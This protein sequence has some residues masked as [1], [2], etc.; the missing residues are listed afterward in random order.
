MRTSTAVRCPSCDASWHADDA[1][2]CGV[3][4]EHLQPLA[5]P[6]PA[7]ARPWLRI[8][9]G[10][11]VVAAVGCGLFAVGGISSL[12]LP[13]RAANP[14]VELGQEQL[15]LEGEPLSEAERAAALAPFDEDRLRCEPEG[16]ERWRVDVEGRPRGRVH[17]TVVDDLVVAAF[18]GEV[19][20]YD[21]DS[22]EER[23]RTAWPD[24][25]DAP[26][27]SSDYV[28]IGHAGSDVLVV[29]WLPTGHVLALDRRGRVLWHAREGVR[30]YIEPVGEVVVAA[31]PS[32]V[33]VALDGGGD[34]GLVFLKLDDL[35]MLD[36]RTG[37]LLW[38]AEAVAVQARLGHA[39]VLHDGTTARL[40]DART[41]EEL[42]RR[43]MAQVPWLQ[44]A[45]EVLVY[46]GSD[47]EDRLWRLLSAG[48]LGDVAEIGPVELLQPSED[49]SV[50]VGQVRGDTTTG[51]RVLLFEPD[52]TLRWEHEL[53]PPAGS[54]A[55][56]CSRP[57]VEGDDLVLPPP[58]GATAPL[59]FE[60]S[61]G[62]PRP[63]PPAVPGSSP[64]PDDGAGTWWAS[65]HTAL[66]RGV[67]A[68][69]T[70]L[71]WHDGYRMSLRGSFSGPLT[72]EPPLVFTGWGSIIA[73]QPV[74][75]D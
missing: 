36:P 25:A 55:T 20:G 69:D 19:F 38:E 60:L 33:E 42:A 1:R 21:L 64:A 73:V 45:G 3:C 2:F 24:A 47:S 22:G 65:P 18:R 56:C 16:C 51:D 6:E 30:G 54:V 39:L 43:T 50:L 35:R 29:G 15:A 8:A 66:I 63:A 37:G 27:T 14:A 46:A 48:D 59:R 58:A 12:R 74:P 32:L 41:G 31:R 10:L 72:T 53:P 13:Q 9:V 75:R 71:V 44:P 40:H 26:P 61:D 34:V 62:T 11:V 4:G 7:P 57:V 70:T 52:G 23:W 49:A 5:P 28:A 17:A 67:D 68:D